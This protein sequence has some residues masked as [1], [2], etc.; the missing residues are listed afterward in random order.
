[1][2]VVSDASPLITLFDGR[3]IDVLHEIF[4]IVLISNHVH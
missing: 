2:I 1:M 4:E 3:S